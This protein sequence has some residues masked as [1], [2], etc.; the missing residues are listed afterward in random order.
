MDN[1]EIF[2]EFLDYVVS[3]EKRIAEL[4]D[5]SLEVESLKAEVQSIRAER[6]QKISDLSIV[7]NSLNKLQKDFE[8]IQRQVSVIPKLAEEKQELHNQIKVLKEDG[9]IS[10]VQASE[11]KKTLAQKNYD[12]GRLNIDKQKLTKE[13]SE[14]KR[15]VDEIPFKYVEKRVL[16]SELEKLRSLLEASRTI[17]NNAGQRE[18]LQGFL[19]AINKIETEI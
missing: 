10:P 13:L 4:R 17:S 14:L 12:L 9:N 11:L 8:D 19:A 6:D 15:V 5:F 18:L 7:E 2:K 16:K 3:L 1:I